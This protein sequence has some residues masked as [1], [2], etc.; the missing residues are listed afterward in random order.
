[1]NK[2]LKA[3][4]DLLILARVHTGTQRMFLEDASVLF[5]SIHRFDRGSFYPGGPDG[6][7]SSAGRGEGLGYTINIPWSRSGAGQ[8][9]HPCKKQ[10]THTKTWLPCHICS[11][12]AT[13]GVVCM[14]CEH[15]IGITSPHV[16][17]KKMPS[18]KD[19]PLNLRQDKS[20]CNCTRANL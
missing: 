6:D 19:A 15:E 11:V 14:A 10:N 2:Q 17:D 18:F 9:W 16:R 8:A 1:V 20:G 3:A 13:R 12:R 4:S 7:F 5:V